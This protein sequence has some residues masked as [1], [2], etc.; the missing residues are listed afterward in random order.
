MGPFTRFVP[1]L[2]LVGV[3]SAKNSAQPNFSDLTIKTKQVGPAYSSVTTL[4]LKGARQRME[5][6]SDNP[7]SHSVIISQ[8]DEGLQ[9]RLNDD[10]KLYAELPIRTPDLSKAAKKVP[11]QAS[12][13]DVDI[14]VN[15][16]DT[17]ERRQIGPYEARHVKT[18]TTV[19][20]PAGASMKSKVEEKDGW[21]VDIPS[22][23][24]RQ[25]QG[26]AFMFTRFGTK[27]DKLH[28]HW[29]G[30]APRGYPIEETTRTTQGEFTSSIKTELLGVS[31]EP[32]S[33][34]L[35]ERPKNYS[36]A[37]HLSNGGIDMRRPETLTNR[38]YVFLADLKNSLTNWM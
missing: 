16:T 34:S 7:N 11:V 9:I 18:T 10:S 1:L 32:I 24:C 6:V 3:V 37:K 13:L 8:C 15:S 38:V 35:F 4:Y 27:Q 14:T 5:Y 36:V 17:G 23:Y 29:S 22:L 12:G 20:A 31:Q 33:A 19:D 2:L 30:P 26:R 21:Y 25:Q 28:F